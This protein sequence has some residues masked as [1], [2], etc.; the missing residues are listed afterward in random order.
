MELYLDSANLEEIKEA[1]ELGFLSGL[2][3]T[4]TFMHRHGITD[5]DATI[6]EL[7]NIVPVLQIEALGNNAEEI[8]AE[9]HRQDAL[10]LNKENTV[11]KIPIS[12]EGV[13]ACKKLTDAG[14]K[15]NIH[16][17]YTLQQAYMA[18]QAGATYVCPLVG[19]LQDQGH[20][21]LSLVQQCVDA[22][23]YYGYDS[24]IMFSS[25]RNIEHV[26]N[27]LNIGVHTITA[28]WNIIQQMSK[29]N[30]TDLGTQQFV[31]HTRLMTYKVKDVL[32]GDN[33]IATTDNT[34]SECLLKMTVGKFG[35]V[36]IVNE[37][38]EAIGIFTDG[39]LR[40]LIA[41]KGADTVNQKVSDTL[42]LVKPFTIDENEL[43]FEANNIF[44]RN[45]INSIVVTSSNK[46]VGMMHLQNIL[47]L[48]R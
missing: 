26:R 47:G 19:R 7:S 15:V 24:K 37:K 18:M 20:D 4:P 39:D 48:E 21:A 10:G 32:G 2:T 25:V 41:S 11:Y 3:T 17:V 28:P 40:R 6:I 44:Q 43:L 29:N 22:V 5:I 13:K 33:P 12:L 34:I 1:F 35:A 14:F 23:E 45:P 16:L 31:E 46:V 42:T 38:N 9:V 36:T 8:I 30:L 27:A